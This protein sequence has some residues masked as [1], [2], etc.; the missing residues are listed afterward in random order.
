MFRFSI[1]SS[2]TSAFRSSALLPSSAA[3]R[4]RNGSTIKY[5]IAPIIAARPTTPP[6]T[7]P[8]IAAVLLAEDVDATACGVV[9]VVEVLVVDSLELLAIVVGSVIKLRDEVVV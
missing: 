3:M 6:T 5:T 7:P 1:E 8:A 9:V 4:R 2:P